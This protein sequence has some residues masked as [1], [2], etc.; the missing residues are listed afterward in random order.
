MNESFKALS[1]PTR[2][3]IL[4]LLREKDMTAGEIADQFNMTKPSISHHL[5]QLKQAKLV[6]DERKGQHIIYSLNTS[7]V[8]E[9]VGWFLD[10]LEKEEETNNEH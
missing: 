1:D 4:R 6:I 8:Q 7:V 3:K 2:R 9:M 10:I 5:N